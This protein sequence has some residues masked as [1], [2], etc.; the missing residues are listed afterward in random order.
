MLVGEVWLASGQSNMQWSLSACGEQGRAAVAAA[1]RPGVRMFTVANRALLGRQSDVEGRWEVASPATAGAFSAVAHHF[2]SKLHEALGVPVGI[3]NASWGGTIVEAWTSREAL[4]QN[5]DTRAWTEL[6]E[7]TV[8]SPAYWAAGEGQPPPYPADPGNSGEAQGWAEPDAAEQSWAEID[9]P[10][11]W[12]AAGHAFSGVFWF[13][14]AV[15]IPERWR[16]RDLV[17]GVGA[18]DKHDVT[19]FNG[20][21]VGSTGRGLEEEHWNQPRVY[22]VPGHLVVPGPAVIAVR[23]FSFV[24]Q[25]GLLGPASAMSVAPVDDA[26]DTIALAGDW[27]YRIEHDLGFV[28]PPTQRW[29]PGNPNS[30]YMLFDNMISPL[31]PYALAGA[32]WYQ[33]ESN[34]G[35]ASQYRGMLTALIR[36]WRRT[37]GQGD[38]AFIQVQLANHSAPDIYQHHSG[39]AL[40]RDAQRRVLSEPRTGMAVA[41]DVG[42]ALDIH[43]HNKQ[44]VGNRL[45][46]WA[47]AIDYGRRG[48]ASGPLYRA[49]TIEPGAIRIHFDHVGSGLT[50][51]DGR[52]PSHFVVA[53]R[54]QRFRP[55]SATIDG[56]TVVVTS[57]DVPQP[58]AVRYAWADN[59]DGCNLINH[60][61]LPASPFRTDCA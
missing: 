36:D 55:A 37:W 35:N 9:L 33:G 53:G 7:A 11:P 41:I 21:R 24:H 27:R 34:I 59:P 46:Q 49:M 19:Y 47:L 54:D 18:V 48:V 14:R 58:L 26:N 16:G 2:A 52:A 10:R 22:R 40:L 50:T 44:D 8:A 38:F 23:A 3:L 32:V 17:V 6:Y 51:R 28:E 12:Q 31:A 61:G 56:A 57:P 1:D 43:P 15:H 20:Q 42:D 45:A 13:R 29:G 4:V 30:P 25:G 39:W 5:E 60:E